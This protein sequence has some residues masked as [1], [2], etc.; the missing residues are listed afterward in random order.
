MKRVQIDPSIDLYFGENFL[1]GSLQSYLK[2]R[3]ALLLAD[4]ALLELY[5]VD[6]AKKLGVELV[7]VPSGEEAKSVAVAEHLISKLCQKGCD[8][9]TFFLAFGGGVTTDLVGFIAS[10][11]M[12]GAPLVLIP[13]TLLAIV[14]ASI[15]AKTAVNTSYGKNLLGTF[16]PPKAI[17][18]DLAMLA[19]LPSR[20]LLNGWAEILKISLVCDIEI[21]LLAKERKEEAIFRA[22]KKKIEIVLKD[23]KE[24]AIRHILNFGHTI[25]HALEKISNYQLSHGEAVAI[26]SV[27]ESYLS[28]DLGLL[29]PKLFEQIQHAYSQFPL[30]LP[31]AYTKEAL[32]AAMSFDKK[33]EGED[34]YF[35]LI[36]RIGHALPF[37]GRYCKKVTPDELKNTL[38]WMESCRFYP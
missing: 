25:G 26:G 2:G 20:E 22:M 32:L 24:R 33:R 27:A 29:E 23:P 7:A 18:A 8:R 15:G 9:N 6:L 10:I 34:L 1:L 30:K 36:D 14:D 37:E 3:R 31:K 17:F 28:M 16:Y 21:W 19:T 12:R 5:A 38:N 13:T 35:V 11:Y 4:S